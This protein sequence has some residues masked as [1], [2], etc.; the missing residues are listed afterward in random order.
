MA[1]GALGDCLWS[2]FAMLEYLWHGMHPA[3]PGTALLP[4]QQSY[5]PHSLS[6]ETPLHLYQEALRQLN[7]SKNHLADGVSR[8]R[9]C[10]CLL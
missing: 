4:W 6:A 5:K 2:S 9:F 7:G 3:P 8:L 1:E 10:P